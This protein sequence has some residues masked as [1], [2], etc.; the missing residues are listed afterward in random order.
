MKRLLTGSIM[1]CLLATVAFAQA[2]D[3]KE[4][5]PAVK[6]ALESRK[7]RFSELRA[8]KS[9]GVVGENN[10]GYVQA[11][12]DGAEVK[13][14]V[15]AENKD[16]KFVYEAIVEQNGLD[17]SALTTVEKVFAR[18]QRDKAAAGDKVQDENG[19]W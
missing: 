15:N 4:M 9:Q 10:R 11:L 8:L 16:R 12:S 13:A 18:V 7:S 1:L 2:Y 17:A 14:L 6:A 3:I 5:T 19:G